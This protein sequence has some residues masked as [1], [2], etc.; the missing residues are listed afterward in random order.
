MAWFDLKAPCK[1]CPFRRSQARNYA[2]PKERLRE[3]I[4]ATAFECHKTTGVAGPKKDPQQC[5]GLIAALNAAGRPNTIMQV[6]NRLEGITFDHID[7]T[8]TFRSLED[9]M[10]GHGHKKGQ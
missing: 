4:E 8:D 10:E 3:I 6:A 1:D 9:L 7:T 5:A 2:L